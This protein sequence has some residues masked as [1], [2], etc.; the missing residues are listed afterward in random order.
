MNPNWVMWAASI[1]GGMKED[2]IERRKRQVCV[3]VCLTEGGEEGRR[4]E[5][6]AKETRGRYPVVLYRSKSNFDF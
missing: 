2:K 4:I 3:C 1:N 6:P 5:S